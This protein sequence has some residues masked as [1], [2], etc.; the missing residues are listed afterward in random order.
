MTTRDSSILACKQCELMLQDCYILMILRI[1]RIIVLDYKAHAK[2]INKWVCHFMSVLSY[3][4]QC[5]LQALGAFSGWCC[6]TAAVHGP[7]MQW[8]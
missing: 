3:S 4:E 2:A 8:R 1:P 6:S 7:P 5:F